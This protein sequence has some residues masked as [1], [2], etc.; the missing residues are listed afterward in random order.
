MKIKVRGLRL[1]LDSTEIDIKN[2][3][4]KQLMIHPK[5]IQT[6]KIVKKAVD[7]R[8]KKVYFI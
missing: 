3:A 7:A 6:M 8:R 1:G 4:A 5:F 2:E